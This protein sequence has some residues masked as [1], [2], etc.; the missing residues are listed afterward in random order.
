MLSWQPGWRPEFRYWNDEW[1]KD[2]FS[3]RGFLG[4]G[5]TERAAAGVPAPLPA[6]MQ[7]AMEAAVELHRELLTYKITIPPE[8]AK[9]YR[10]SDD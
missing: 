9:D 10:S 6:N 1:V 8:A 4:G 2:V 7:E 3:S 5:S